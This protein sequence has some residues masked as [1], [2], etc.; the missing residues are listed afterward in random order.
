MKRT[1]GRIG[2]VST[3]LAGTDGVSLETV[4]WSNVLTDRGHEC[5]YFAGESD[6]PEERTRLVPEAHFK[7]PVI[8]SL[9]KE[10][11]T[12]YVR[13]PKI[14][15]KIHEL[16]NYLKNQLYEFAG[17]FQLD[18][19]ITENALSLPMNI[20]L[21]LALTEFI[22]E[23]YFPTL[24]HH[25]DFYWERERYAVTAADDYI[26]TAFPP[27]LR[28]VTHVVI[29]SFA[30]RQLALR[31]GAASTLIP[32]VMDFDSPPPEADEYRADFRSILGIHPDEYILLQPTR[33]VP[34]KRIEHAIELARRIGL[35]CVLVISH[36]SGDEGAGYQDYLLDYAKLMGVRIIL[37]SDIINHL[38]SHTQDGKKIFSIADVYR[39]ANLVTYPST[40]E[41]FGNAFLETI[42][43][44]K[45]IVMSTYEIFRAD[46]QPKGFKVI[47]FENFITEDTI[48][49]AKAALIDVDRVCEMT[50]HNYELGRT[51]YSYRILE[52]RLASLVSE[53][54][55]VQRKTK[56][57]KGY[58]CH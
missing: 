48:A 17:D 18:L 20:P 31:S 22:A 40:V 15:Q 4:K 1:K 5:F 13:S 30:G 9:N 45:P 35:K 2:F 28:S 52:T 19:L 24:A 44:K 51:Y 21:G 38:R 14:S 27:T 39:E 47:G 26:R 25:H 7:H 6:W 29:N 16:K 53:R 55:R 37:A 41:G 54:I 33:I 8:E 34:R 50:E 12:D 36:S 42:Y 56:G 10:L 23:N 43:F 58:K 32:N 3:R 57:Y 11:F 46:I 49:Q